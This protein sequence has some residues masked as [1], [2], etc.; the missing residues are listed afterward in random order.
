MYINDYLV[1]DSDNHNAYTHTD[2]YKR[3]LMGNRR[4]MALWGIVMRT[5]QTCAETTRWPCGESTLPHKT[6]VCIIFR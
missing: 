1:T 4:E 3:I 6:I 5:T 2:T